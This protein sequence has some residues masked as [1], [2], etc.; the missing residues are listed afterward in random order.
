MRIL[1]VED[2]D[3]IRSMIRT[4]IEGRGHEVEAV[5]TGVKGIDAALA[6]RPDAILLELQLPG[7]FD[8]LDVCRQLRAAEA[9]RSVPIIVISATADDGVK[10]RA[11]EAGASAY[12][13]KPFSPTAL[14]KELESI[15]GS[16]PS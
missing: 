2:S 3:S 13:T 1:V 15:T 8:G 16:H 9:T 11:L 12:Y 5:S 7:S 10:G 14:L 6:R 4:F